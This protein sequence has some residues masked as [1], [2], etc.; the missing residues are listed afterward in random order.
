MWRYGPG[1]RAATSRDDVVDEDVR[2]LLPDRERAEPDVDPGVRRGGDAVGRQP[3][4]RRE[5]GVDVP[6]HVDLRHDV[7][8]APPRVGDDPRVLPLREVPS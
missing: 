3:A 1:V 4:V 2:Q 5:R 8:E 6:R 7:D